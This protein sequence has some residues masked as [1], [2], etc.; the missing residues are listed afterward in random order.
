MLLTLCAAVPCSAQ[1]QAEPWSVRMAAT[2]MAAHPDSFCYDK[3]KPARWDYELGLYMKSLEQLWRQTGDGAYFHYI[4]KQMDF[5]IQPDGDI[6]TYKTEVYNIDHITP[7]RPVL[8]LWQQTGQEKYRKAAELLRRQLT[9]HPRTRE[10]GFWHKKRYPWQMWLDGLYMG[11]PYYAEYSVLFNEPQNFDDIANQFIWMEKNARDAKT[12]LLYHAWDESREQQWANKNTGQSPHFWGRAMGWYAM[13]LV[14]VLDYFPKDHPKYNQIVSILQRL[15]AAVTEVQ[16]AQTGVWYQVLDRANEPGN[17]REASG[18]CMFAYAL[19]KGA[20]LGYLDAKYR[21]VGKK[22]YAGILKE[23]MVQDTDGSW[24]LDKVCMVAGLGGNPYRDGTFQYYVSEPIRRDDLKGAGPFVLAS[25]EMERLANVPVGAGKTVLLDRFF[26][27]E[28]RNGERYHYTWEDI[29]DSGYAW[30]GQIFRDMGAATASLD[31]APTDSNLKNADVY[32]IVDPDT[33]KETPN[34]NFVG[35]QHVE[36]IKNWVQNGGTLVLLANDTSNCEIPQFN[37][38]AAEFGIRFTDKNRNMVKN[39]QFE[40]GAIPVPTGHPIFHSS[41]KLYIKELSVLDVRP[42]AR[43]ALT[44]SGD[45]I[46]ATA[47]FGKGRVF[48]LGDPWIYNEYLDGKKLPA[49]FENFNAARDLSAWLL[50]TADSEAAGVAHAVEM[51]RQ[52]LLSG[53]RTALENITARELTYG[54]SSG[55]IENKTDFVEQ[56]AS[57]RS[58]FTEINFSEQTISV[59]GQTATVRHIL[60]A[61]TNDAGKGPGTVRLAV[62]LVWVKQQDDWK[63]LARQAVKI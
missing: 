60:S 62:L 59:V 25:L 8:L 52:A 5:Y 40:Q 2:L 29:K 48:A 50:Q 42:P 49:E 20:R 30:W 28:Y 56:L 18:S 1:T 31:A 12:G 26:N 39:N 10:G 54:H 36:T 38:L 57:G 45:V 9:D 16:D 6:R 15:A 13:G 32:I 58:D 55:K 61:A 46:M 51:L 24:H 19:L 22:A 44:E 11:E 21:E 63:L 27:N 4:R 35:K 3:T 33:R 37:Q 53:D 14:D 17:Y 23:F 47:S 34:P 41:R 43:A 7:G